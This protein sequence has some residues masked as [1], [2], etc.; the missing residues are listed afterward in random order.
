MA[1]LSVQQRHDLWAGFMREF[2]KAE[3]LGE[4]TKDQLRAAVDAL[5]QF[6]SDNAG[7]VNAAIPQ[8]ARGVLTTRQKAL[9]LIHV[10]RARYVL[11]G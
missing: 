5:D 2:P 8:P 11:E 1:V 7:T 4:I 9:L 6:F 10:I 3:T